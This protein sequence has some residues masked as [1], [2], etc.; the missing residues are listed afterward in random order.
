MF[1]AMRELRDK[2]VPVGEVTFYHHL[3]DT[4]QIDD[5]GGLEYLLGMPDKGVIGE[6]ER[7]AAIVREKFLL[8]RMVACCTD[9]V[10]RVY[11]H[12][13]E[14]SELLDQFET[15]CLG[16]R[17]HLETVTP[18]VDIAAVQQELVNEYELAANGG[19]AMGLLTGYP[20]LDAMAGGM[21]PQE[22]IAIAG[23]RS[24][25]KTSLA[26]NI[27]KRVAE[28]GVV[29]GIQSLET[30]GKKLIHRMLAGIGRYDASLLLRGIKTAGLA[31]QTMA[32]FRQIK[33]FRDRLIIDESGSITPEQLGAKSRRMI[34]LGA[35]LLI[36]DYLQLLIVPGKSEYERVTA[37]SRCV[38]KLAKSLNVP[39]IVV[40]SLNRESDRDSRK[41]KMSD[42]RAS[43]QIEYDLDK[44]ILLH[45]EDTAPIRKVTADVAKNK[46]GGVG[47]VGFTFYAPQFRFESIAKI[48]EKDVPYH[49][50]HN[51]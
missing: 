35:K 2:G 15:D 29:V 50:P 11:E 37:A 51:D 20:D 3:K 17:R 5:A 24:S 39:V 28:S 18:F 8:R 33:T 45:S 47:E 27:A 46:D 40:A 43:G 4:N 36:V 13:G 22:M 12:Q 9:L 25:G 30:S 14:A 10:A 16:L 26:M 38:K 44:A 42:L 6:M 21:M 31:D 32:A 7:Y 49:D 41:P 23:L 19:K 1:R 48:D 34:K